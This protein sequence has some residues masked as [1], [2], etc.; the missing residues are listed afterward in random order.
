MNATE[1]M[2]DCGHVA[3]ATPHTP[4]YGIFD[5]RKL[6][7]S[8]CDSEELRKMSE[9]RKYF[10]Y[11]SGDG[12]RITSWPGGTLAVVTR[13]WTVTNNMAGKLYRIRATMG[14]G[15][16]W[17]GTSPGPGMYCRLTRSRQ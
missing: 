6:C 3:V 12:K 14:D 16:R 15:S 13:L 7:Y 17:H 5:G 10:A 2:C 11:L 1:T 4:G 9:S 8:C